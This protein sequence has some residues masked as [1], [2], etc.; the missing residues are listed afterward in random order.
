M[1]RF[2]TRHDS[3][4]N[5]RMPCSTRATVMSIT[6]MQRL[7]LTFAPGLRHC[8]DMS[9]PKGPGGEAAAARPSALLRPGLARAATSVGS[10]VPEML[11][12]LG[13]ARSAAAELDR[14]QALRSYRGWAEWIDLR[15][16]GQPLAVVA[17]V[18][19]GRIGAKLAAVIAAADPGECP[20][21]ELCPS[22]FIPDQSS[23][24]PRIATDSLAGEVV[25]LVRIMLVRDLASLS[26]RPDLI[27]RLRRDC[28]LAI[29]D[30]GL[31]AAHEFDGFD[32]MQGG[33][34]LVGE[35][36]AEPKS[37]DLARRHFTLAV[38]PALELAALVDA[39][40]PA[41]LRGSTR[42][43][44]MVGDLV[45]LAE[46]LGRT[47]A[48]LAE[49]VGGPALD[50]PNADL[51]ARLARL[52]AAKIDLS[53]AVKACAARSRM[54]RQEVD[55]ARLSAH[56]ERGQFR[57]FLDRFHSESG[58]SLAALTVR[59][60][61]R[62][63]WQGT[64]LVALGGFFNRKVRH[65][66]ANSGDAESSVSRLVEPYREQ[67]LLWLGRTLQVASEDLESTVESIEA[68]YG[69]IA[70][71]SRIR[72]PLRIARRD[73]IGEGAAKEADSKA[74]MVR[75][76][77]DDAFAAFSAREQ[78][79]FYVDVEEKGVVGQ[80]GEARSGVFG[81]FF[82]LLFFARPFGAV[83]TGLITALTA[84]MVIGT[85][86]AFVVNRT[87]RERKLRTALIERFEVRVEDLRGRVADLAKQTIGDVLTRFEQDTEDFGALA[88]ATL[89]RMMAETQAQI[90][91]E[92]GAPKRWTSTA[93]SATQRGT[94]AALGP[95]PTGLTG[96]GNLLEEC[97]KLEAKM[98]D[99]YVGEVCRTPVA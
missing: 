50:G 90:E 68:A 44:G 54:L 55:L 69:D 1:L 19:P 94:G 40:V 5:P 47:N 41:A 12:R 76:T 21:V 81:I 39:A 15:G 85:L 88:D 65:R 97:R 32:Q 52:G 23:E 28:A 60:E 95:R 35:G 2:Q 18:K 29:A 22:T 36:S 37:T 62:A 74:A 66:L 45:A 27:G 67:T 91:E 57:E 7:G 82:L 17:A 24:W 83:L 13:E 16:R 99:A 92:G 31:I 42:A 3:V 70:E 9:D 73:V 96:R 71:A 34:I 79:N 11:Q 25:P 93:A 53:G 56:A 46:A 61:K 26:A 6:L 20:V 84:A 4:A 30:A 98:H 89:A 51:G 77:V 87:M 80:L 63:W 49:A 10:L 48:G 58:W 64:W 14:R 59:D 43:M 33:L 72:W 78:A 86:I 75:K 38:D 8:P